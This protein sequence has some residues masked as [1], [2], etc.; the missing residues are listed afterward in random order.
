MMEVDV[1]NRRIFLIVLDSFGIG[2][3]PDAA[4]FGDAG[5]NTLKSITNS[6]K[7][8]TPNMKNMG[9]FH[10]DGVDWMERIDF[11]VGAFGRMK[12]QSRGKD[13]TIGHWEIAGIISPK[14]LPTY[15]QGFPDEVL[16]EFRQKTGRQILCNKPYSG[17]D[18]IRDYGEE[19]MKT[20]ALIVYT[21][22]VCVSEN[23]AHEA[24]V[25]VED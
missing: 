15:P 25:P 21:S 7:Y 10:I 13:T 23:A 22:A 16:D 8:D 1:L 14:P 19:H 11:P 12:E 20:G 4:D 17:T 3:Q 18:V 24:V 5:C 9:L 2:A 6:S